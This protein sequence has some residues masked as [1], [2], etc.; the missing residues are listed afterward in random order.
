MADD[1]LK[2]V[3]DTTDL[4]DDNRNGGY[5]TPDQAEVFIDYMWDATVLG[6]QVRT[7]RLR[8]NEAD[9]DRIHVGER[10]IRKGV[11]ATDT[12]ENA[13]V[14]FSKI[15][16]RTEKIRLDWELSTE[17]LEDNLEGERLEDHIARMMATQL[18]ND[19]EDVAINGDVDS[20]DPALS[21][22]DG[23]S[24]RLLG[25]SDTTPDGAHVVDAG[26]SVFGRDVVN[27]ALKAV[28]RKYMQRR[29]DLRLYVGSSF[30]QDYLYG[31]TQSDSSLIALDNI[32]ANVAVNGPVRT[33]GPAGFLSMRIFGVTVQEVPMFS[34]TNEGSY[35]GATGEDHGDAWL[36][37]PKNLIWGVKRE[38][39]IYRQFVQKKD[40]IEY[41]VFTRV[42]TQVENGDAAVVI[43]DI[44]GA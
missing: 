30:I 29:G 18:G 22:M 13:Q 41:T 12:G 23:W 33:E 19:L 8:A 17:V 32:A 6:S 27:Q 38:V 20:T 14:T 28:P 24:K 10:L 35:S 5:L 16:L 36:T 9:L 15:N 37:F 26:G 4:G 7:E 25:D 1:V 2:K 40:S 3:I 31:L 39:K 11:E 21:I 43:R 34:T 42:G 44:A